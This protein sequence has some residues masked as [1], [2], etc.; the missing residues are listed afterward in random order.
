M[1]GWTEGNWVY[2]LPSLALDETAPG[3][4]SPVMTPDPT[5]TASL[6]CQT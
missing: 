4:P 5:E 6:T 1:D 3:R 2:G